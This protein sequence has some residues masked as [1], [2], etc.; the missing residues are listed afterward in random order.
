MDQR[1][2]KP[3]KK[4]YGYEQRKENKNEKSNRDRAQEWAKKY[5]DDK[6]KKDGK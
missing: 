2:G 3:E 4:G 5:G 1:G 6:K